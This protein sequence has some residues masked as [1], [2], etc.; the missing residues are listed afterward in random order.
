MPLPSPRDIAGVNQKLASNNARVSAA[1]NSLPD[2]LDRLVAA[3][4]RHDWQEVTRQSESL[5]ELG[6]SLKCDSLV[7]PAS[8]LAAAAE[9]RTSE[10]E[11]KR[12][13]L[14]VIGA[15]GKAKQL[16]FL[17]GR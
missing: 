12:H 11:I 4:D 15:A 9:A 3:A 6:R 1:L 5:A 10:F 13:L 2:W 7:A 8:Q 14:R 16:P 17:A